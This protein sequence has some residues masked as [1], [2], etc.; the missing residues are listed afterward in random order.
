[1][2]EIQHFREAHSQAPH[3]GV[4]GG[5]GE[6]YH[7][8]QSY[9]AN[10]LAQKILC[11][12]RKHPSCVFVHFFRKEIV[13]SKAGGGPYHRNYPLYYHHSVK[14]RPALA[15]G[16]HRA[17]YN[18]RLSRVEPGNY[19]A[20]NRHEQERYHRMPVF[21]RPHFFFKCGSFSQDKRIFC[22][23]R[24]HRYTYGESPNEQQRP[25]KRIY[26]AN[27]FIYRENR[28]AYVIKEYR[29]HGEPEYRHLRHHRVYYLSRNIHKNCNHK[30]QQQHHEYGKYP[31][32]F[33]S[34]IHSY[35]SRKICAPVAHGHHSR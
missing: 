6:D 13:Y 7:T 28:G 19:A 1:M 11:D 34:E 30:K 29:N 12:V 26:F 32:K 18:R 21:R 25:E 2:G 31:V 14:G 8:Q 5:Y 20:G 22:R 15:L 3:C 35:E 16:L 27:Y 10:P 24:Y 17:R 9:R 33:I 23:V 4:S